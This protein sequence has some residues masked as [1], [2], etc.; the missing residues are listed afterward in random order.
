MG[1]EPVLFP[2]VF[3]SLKETRKFIYKY[4]HVN[5]EWL[6]NNGDINEYNNKP[7]RPIKMIN[8]IKVLL[9]KN[10]ESTL[11]SMIGRNDY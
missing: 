10:I 5:P 1:K 11:I 4:A 9:N 6:N 2:E 3:N 7:S 8:G